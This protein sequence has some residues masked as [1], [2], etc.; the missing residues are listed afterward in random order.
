MAVGDDLVTG[1]FASPTSELRNYR[2]PE[3]EDWEWDPPACRAPP[4]PDSGR[5]RPV[6]DHKPA[7]RGRGG[8]R[9]KGNRVQ[10]TVSLEAEIYQ[11][12]IEL[13]DR[14]GIPITDVISKLCA[15]ALGLPVPEYCLP[16]VQDQENL[17]LVDVS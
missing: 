6:D 10:T 7:R 9:R 16:K 5:K 13:A 3:V 15:E 17:P 1:R 8:R 12:V 14:D 4:R 11:G 2:T